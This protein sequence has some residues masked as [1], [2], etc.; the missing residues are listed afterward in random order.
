MHW[1]T[2]PQTKTDV[3]KVEP[4]IL[5]VGLTIKQIIEIINK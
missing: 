2:S 4:N 5:K 3:I 1:Q